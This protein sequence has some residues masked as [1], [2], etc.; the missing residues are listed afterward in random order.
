MLQIRPS[1]AK[2]WVFRGRFGEWQSVRKPDGS[3]TRARKKRELGLGPYP[4]V[5]PGEA[6]EKARHLRTKLEQGID[7]LAEKK[8]A[9]TKLLMAAR[10]RRTFKQAF[11]EYAETKATEFNGEK[12]RKQWVSLAER[13]A[14]PSLGDLLVQD[15]DLANVLF[16]LKP[17][18]ETKN[19]TATKLRQIVEGTLDF[20]TVHGYRTGENPARWQGNLS[21]VLGSPTKVSKEQN[22]P[23]VQVSLVPSRARVLRHHRTTFWSRLMLVRPTTC[24][25]IR[26]AVSGA[27]R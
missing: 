1:G 22:Y 7:P 24:C 18:W 14:I 16:V 26:G 9:Q 5:L 6:R 2:S 12:Y 21:V 10:K 3:Q 11:D 17:I 27:S 15:I 4:D 20:S 23:A 8:E 25:S 19:P 13:H